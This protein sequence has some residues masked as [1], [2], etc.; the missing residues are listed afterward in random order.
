MSETKEPAYVLVDG[1]GTTGNGTDKYEIVYSSSMWSHFFV[2]GAAI[3]YTEDGVQ[4][5]NKK[6]KATM[7]VGVAQP[8]G[9]NVYYDENGNEV[10]VTD[11]DNIPDGVTQYFKEA[12]LV[13]ATITGAGTYK[14]AIVGYNFQD[15]DDAQGFN[16]LYLTSNIGYFNGE[17]SNVAY[18]VDGATL[19]TTITEAKEFL[20]TLYEDLAELEALAAEEEETTD[21]EEETTDTE[22][23]TE[24]TEESTEAATEETTEEDDLQAEIEELEA[25]I[26]ALEEAIAAGEAAAEYDG[27]ALESDYHLKISSMT[28]YGYD[29]AEA[30]EAGEPDET[31]A[32]PGFVTS[33]SG[34][35]SEFDFCDY[36]IVNVY[37][38]DKGF[39]DLTSTPTEDEDGEMSGY[40]T[41]TMNFNTTDGTFDAI[42]D[43]VCASSSGATSTLP[44]YALEIEFTVAEGDADV[45]GYQGDIDA[46]TEAILAVIA[47]L[48]DE[49]IVEEP[50]ECYF[51][52]SPTKGQYNATLY[53]ANGDWSTSSMAPQ[54]VRSEYNEDGRATGVYV[55]DAIVTGDGTYTVKL[56]YPPEG[57][58]KGGDEYVTGKITNGICENL[59]CNSWSSQNGGRFY[60]V[61]VFCV[62]IIGLLDGT[63]MFNDYKTGYVSNTATVESLF[64]ETAGPYKASLI[65]TT[66]D[67]IKQDGVLVPCNADEIICGNID[68]TN[69]SYR[70]EI[71]NAYGDTVDGRV[72]PD[73]NIDFTDSL[74]VTF[75]ISGLDAQLPS[76]GD[77]NIDSKITTADVGLANSHAKGV[78]LLSD[79]LIEIAD[80]NSD[81][82]VTTADVGIINAYAKGIR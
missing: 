48:S 46:A 40:T 52:W 27:T 54:S 33:T 59:S 14:A 15:T 51:G 80:M 8:G 34:D 17:V 38:S 71:F 22:D 28:V 66:V 23:A 36:N 31:Y 65:T 19:K 6:G 11:T 42:G 20:D 7:T 77:I 3:A 49:D 63:E 56:E 53:I 25:N 55:Q 50:T 74:E 35:P 61:T 72:M 4:L 37:S 10:E 18:T 44:T 68:N 32:V 81:G 12:E 43:S 69:Y 62:D 24:A 2:H 16:W 70:I 9:S 78:K 1:E 39:A 13:D 5:Y 60:A 75:T 30:Y 45:F 64:G 58:T 21:A 47:S 26:A 82:R 73:D 41:G 76:L 67:S 29:S 79:G 57:D